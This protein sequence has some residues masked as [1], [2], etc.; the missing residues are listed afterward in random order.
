MHVTHQSVYIDRGDTVETHGKLH[1]LRIRSNDNRHADRTCTIVLPSDAS[2]RLAFLD[3]LT[4]ACEL[5][6]RYAYQELGNDPRAKYDPDRPIA[7]NE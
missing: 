3:K 1:E 2:D 5:L 6:G 4:E 7:A